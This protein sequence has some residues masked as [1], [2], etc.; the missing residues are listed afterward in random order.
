MAHRTLAYDQKWSSIVQV[1]QRRI[2]GSNDRKFCTDVQPKIRDA[3]HG[4]ELPCKANGEQLSLTPHSESVPTQVCD[5]CIAA[6]QKPIDK[7]WQSLFFTSAPH[8]GDN[9]QAKPG[10]PRMALIVPAVQ[11][12]PNAGSGGEG[13]PVTLLD[14]WQNRSMIEGRM[15]FASSMVFFGNSR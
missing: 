14:N 2:H 4:Q 15:C 3:I 8:N 5:P 6:A 7:A 10:C 11:K 1:T 13:S 12:N 9:Y